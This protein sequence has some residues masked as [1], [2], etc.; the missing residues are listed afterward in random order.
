MKPYVPQSLPLTGLDYARLIRKIGPANA[1][2]ARY[3][4]LLQSVIN[5]GVMLSP[6]ANR[7]AHLSCRWALIGM[8]FLFRDT[9]LFSRMRCHG[10]RRNV[11]RATSVGS[12]GGCGWYVL[13]DR[14]AQ[15]NRRKVYA[16]GR[17][18]A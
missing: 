1:A 17:L 4:G 8:P 7:D 9:Q 16:E 3:D 2:L 18:P 11:G 6:L 13:T 10:K 5:P 15:L 14:S 12:V